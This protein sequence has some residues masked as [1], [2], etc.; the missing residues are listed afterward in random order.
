MTTYFQITQVHRQWPY[1]Y[2][3]ND[4]TYLT[5]RRIYFREYGSKYMNVYYNPSNRKIKDFEE[6]EIE[7]S[8]LFNFIT[9]LVVY[10]TLEHTF[11]ALYRFTLILCALYRFTLTGCALYRFIITFCAW[12]HPNV[13]RVISFHP[14]FCG[15]YRFTLTICALYRSTL[16]FCALY[17][18]SIYICA[19]D[20][21]TLIYESTLVP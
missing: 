19:L 14:N 10:F 13:L 15:L 4:H 9:A 3:V 17:R 5:E 21:V 11:C 8:L 20:H 18:F 1:K 6:T 16:T 2:I 7:Y 12:Y